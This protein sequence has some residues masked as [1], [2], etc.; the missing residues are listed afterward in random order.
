L[1][2]VDPRLMLI[3]SRYLYESSTRGDT[4]YNLG[5]FTT[6]DFNPSTNADCSKALIAGSNENHGRPIAY[7]GYLNGV[8]YQNVFYIGAGNKIF[9]R[10]PASDQVKTLSYPGDE[11]VTE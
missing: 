4:L 5:C 9:H 1:N 2:A 11:V 7:G 8:A 10:A 6:P 3:G